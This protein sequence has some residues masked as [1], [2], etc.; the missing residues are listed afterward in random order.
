M[1]YYENNSAEIRERIENIIFHADL[2]F[3][4]K[5]KQVQYY[6]AL[7]CGFDIETSKVQLE[8]IEIAVCYHWQFGIEDLYSNEILKI[9]VF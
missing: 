2:V 3:D 1:I 4:R 6:Y 9:P 8:D 5:F 7:G